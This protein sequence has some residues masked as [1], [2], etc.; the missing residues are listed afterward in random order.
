MSHENERIQRQIEGTEKELARLEGQS[1]ELA[2]A[3][4]VLAK[5]SRSLNKKNRPFGEEDRR[6][7]R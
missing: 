2:D 4:F 5:L 6:T 3:K 7:G 1:K